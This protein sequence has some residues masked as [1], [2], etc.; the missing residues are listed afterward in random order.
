MGYIGLSISKARDSLYCLQVMDAGSPTTS[1]GRKEQIDKIA[2]AC[3]RACGIEHGLVEKIGSAS[4]EQ[5]RR[6]DHHI[7]TGTRR[8]EPFAEVQAYPPEPCPVIIE[9]R[10][11]TTSQPA[12]KESKTFSTD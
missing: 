2:R 11:Y 10:Q 5:E 3:A 9:P 8:A 1:D 4:E 6:M 7:R 12:L